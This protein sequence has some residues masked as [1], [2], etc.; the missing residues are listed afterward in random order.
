MSASVIIGIALVCIAGLTLGWSVWRWCAGRK[1][2]NLIKQQAVL[3]TELRKTNRISWQLI[4]NNNGQATARNV[5][6]TLDGR[7]ILKHPAVAGVKQ[8]VRLI[9]SNSHISYIMALS[10]EC[11][12]PFEL[13]ATWDDDSGQPRQYETTLT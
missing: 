13:E 5:T 8:E 4:V 7:P 9:G 10:T 6:I 3:C 1:A 2:N 11:G 12:P